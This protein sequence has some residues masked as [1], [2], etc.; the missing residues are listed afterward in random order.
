MIAL[1]GLLQLGVGL[2]VGRPGPVAGGLVLLGVAAVLTFGRGRRTTVGRGGIHAPRRVRQRELPWS[3]IAALQARSI[4]GGRVRL[5]VQ[6]VGHPTEA[7]VP[8]ATLRA[9]D[10][11][12]L[13]PPIRALAAANDVPVRDT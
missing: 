4:G 3:A 12:R 2:Q 6:Q 10:A 11:E 9:A 7:V 13:L 5:L 1:M 8:L